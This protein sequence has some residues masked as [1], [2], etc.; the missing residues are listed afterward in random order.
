MSIIVDDADDQRLFGGNSCILSP[1]DVILHCAELLLVTTKSKSRRLISVR[2]T[3]VY[4][5]PSTKRVD[6]V[7][8]GAKLIVRMTMT[9]TTTTMLPPMMVLPS[10]SSPSPPIPNNKNNHV[11]NDNNNNSNNNNTNNVLP[12][13]GQIITD[14]VTN[15]LDNNNTNQ[16]RG[17]RW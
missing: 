5:E 13:S 16:Q 12:S 2:G 6:I 1:R 9:T 10:S 8:Q 17:Q 11:P 15:S 3:V 4:V 7:Y 14:V